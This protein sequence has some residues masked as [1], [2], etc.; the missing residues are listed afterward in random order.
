MHIHHYIYMGGCQTDPR[1]FLHVVAFPSGGTLFRLWQGCGQ[2]W[3]A[4]PLAGEWI[5]SQL[6]EAP[7]R[8]LRI[9]ISFLC[10]GRALTLKQDLT[11]HQPGPKGNV[12]DVVDF[13]VCL[14]I[15]AR[16]SPK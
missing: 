2:L 11:L 12:I 5:L 1:G 8:G 13:A 16:S 7:V 3:P 9:S 14:S 15:F 10:A 6:L 4:H